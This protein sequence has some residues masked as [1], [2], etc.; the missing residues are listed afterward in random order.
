M[1]YELN[2]LPPYTAS[3]SLNAQ[4]EIA[5]SSVDQQICI[6]YVDQPN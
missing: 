5:Q 4:E 2:N 3:E 6:L 1:Q